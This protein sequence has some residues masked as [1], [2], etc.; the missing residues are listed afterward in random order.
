MAGG[1]PNGGA[2]PLEHSSVIPQ[3]VKT[4]PAASLLS[5]YL[6]EM[7]TCPHKNLKIDTHNSIIWNS[8][9]NGTH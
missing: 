4:D 1:N 2:V 3:K 9:I 5:V 7:K 8:K 6:T